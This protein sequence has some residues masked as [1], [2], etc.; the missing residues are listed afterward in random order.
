VPHQ[1][2]VILNWSGDDN[3]TLLTGNR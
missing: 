2:N 3:R 1:L